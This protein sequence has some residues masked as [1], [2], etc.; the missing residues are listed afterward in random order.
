MKRLISLDSL[1]DAWVQNANS[2]RVTNVSVTEIAD[3]FANLDEL[4]R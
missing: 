3:K 2:S 4:S 1:G